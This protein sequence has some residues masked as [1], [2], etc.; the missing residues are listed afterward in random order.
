MTFDDVCIRMIVKG[1][2][3]SVVLPVEAPGDF[4]LI[5]S[6]L[7]AVFMLMNKLMCLGFCLHFKGMF[8]PKSNVCS[9]VSPLSV[10]SVLQVFIVS[11]DFKRMV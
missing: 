4:L 9:S 2:L 10:H 6:L 11:F 7:K 1:A 3:A 8:Y 5:V